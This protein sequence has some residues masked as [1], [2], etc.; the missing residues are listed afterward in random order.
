[1]TPRYFFVDLTV[2][3]KYIGV[4]ACQ[5]HFSKELL[6]SQGRKE[7]IIFKI[8]EDNL[9][10]V[11]TGGSVSQIEAFNSFRTNLV[12]PFRLQKILKSAELSKNLKTA[13]GL[14]RG[15]ANGSLVTSQVFDV[16]LMGSYMAVAAAWGAEHPIRWR[17]IRF[18]YN[19]IT[20]LIEPI[21][22]DANL[23]YTKRRNL[24][25][26]ANYD[27]MG[28]DIM[29]SDPEIKIV[30]EATLKKLKDEVESGITEKWVSLSQK[31]H[32]KILHKEY[33]LLGGI[34]LFGMAEVI[35]AGLDR[36]KNLFSRY[37]TILDAH[38]IEDKQESHIELVNPLP[39]PI[40]IS[41][42][43]SVN[44][45]TGEKEKLNILSKP[46]FPF[47]ILRTPLQ[48]DPTSVKLH[49]K[50]TDAKHNKILVT[51]N[52]VGDDKNWKIQ[53]LPYFSARTRE[54]IPLTTLPKVLRIH[55][56]LRHDSDSNSL[57]IPKG[58]WIVKDSLVVPKGMTLNINKGAI[59]KFNP[60]S[61][62]IARGPVI[63]EGTESFP[64][65]LKGLD[66]LDEKS[67][68]QGIS[69]LDSSKPSNW[70][71]VKI[72]NTT[73]VSKDGWALS[74]GVNFYESDIE[75]D[76]VVFSGN[77]SEDALNV[78]RSK[79]DLKNITIKNTT[80]DAF[81]SDFSM[82]LV[83][84]GIFKNI[85]SLGGGDGIDASGSEI[86]VTK[87]NFKNISDK[88]LSVGEESQLKISDVNIEN[89]SIGVASKDGSKVT[90][91]GATFSGI[92]KAGLMAY[93]KK[94]E[95]GPAKITADELEF[96]SI[97]KRAISQKG[98]KILI[99]GVE[100]SPENLQVKELY[101]S[102]SK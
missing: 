5:E 53:A 97:E 35:Q 3:G 65:I 47:I 85:G 74:G 31:K 51:A 1:L 26:T 55:N 25:I 46:N 96:S 67:T 27:T 101:S 44:I 11:D 80:S 86:V 48:N 28:S 73:G 8:V 54:I 68:W 56:Y 78:V 38:L 13:T 99:D 9:S 17:N 39:H 6:E 33:P 84:N 29:E 72:F 2:N 66:E 88:A 94:T 16:E 100:V 41:K 98:N 45:Q 82:G 10:E 23:D 83:E 64:V 15:F 87:S 61:S 22:Y 92:K 7:S 89:V 43:E 36:S 63:I 91:S 42:I 75:M 12:K 19:P 76:H 81:D 50:K 57:Q 34:S 24:D 71:Y 14:F 70:S 4:M 49:Y 37:R 77:K 90:L 93:I 102:T 62:L 95:Y 60:E 58:E 52:I 40:I 59:L 20:G 18:Y 79:F 21:G 32:L 30:Y 69:L